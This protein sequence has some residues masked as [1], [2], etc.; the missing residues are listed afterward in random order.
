MGVAQWYTDAPRHGAA[1]RHGKAQT[2]IG[3]DGGCCGDVRRDSVGKSKLV[4]EALEGWESTVRKTKTSGGELLGEYR[5][6]RFYVSPSAAVSE[7]DLVLV[8]QHV[9]T[10]CERGPDE[11]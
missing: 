5:L 3:S 7:L 4:F 1:M 8:A 11:G 6:V 2:V 9:R 10:S